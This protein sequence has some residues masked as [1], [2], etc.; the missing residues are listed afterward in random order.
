VAGIRIEVD[1][2]DRRLAL[3]QLPQSKNSFPENKLR[4]RGPLC[5]VFGHAGCRPLTA[6]YQI[7]DF[8][9]IVGPQWTAWDVPARQYIRQPAILWRQHLEGHQRFCIETEQAIV[10]FPTGLNLKIVRNWPVPTSSRSI[11]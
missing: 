4:A 7:G 5:S 3:S 10:G 9:D 1:A 2:D 6:E 11:K 8:M